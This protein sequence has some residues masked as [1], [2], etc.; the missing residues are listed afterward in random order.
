MSFANVSHSTTKSDSFVTNPGNS[1]S[2][3]QGEA[4]VPKPFEFLR[5]GSTEMSLDVVS[6]L[7][8]NP[9]VE[10]SRSDQKLQTYTVI[11]R[12]KI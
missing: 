12:N 5:V 2:V 3:I 1:T 4:S 10:N 6:E 9:V 7:E 8:S 11:R